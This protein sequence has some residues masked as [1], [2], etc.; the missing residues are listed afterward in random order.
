[1]FSLAASGLRA[2]ARGGPGP[3]AKYRAKQAPTSRHFTVET[4]ASTY[5]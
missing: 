5:A 2:R 1:L 4:E 3:Q